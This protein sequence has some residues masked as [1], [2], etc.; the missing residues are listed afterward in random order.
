VAGVDF[1]VN[2]KEFAVLA[3]RKRI[4]QEGRRSKVR[5]LSPAY[6]ATFT[7]SAFNR[8]GLQTKNSIWEFG[9]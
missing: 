1:G 8:P 6:D 9:S 3:H 2:V 7:A 4:Q 5:Y